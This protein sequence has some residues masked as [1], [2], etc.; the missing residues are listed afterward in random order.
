M[1][2]SPLDEH[3]KK[4]FSHY[5][6]DVPAHIWERIAAEK[7]RKKPLGFW[8]QPKKIGLLVLLALLFITGGL[9][10]YSSFDKS[11]DEKHSDTVLKVQDQKNA[12]PEVTD[13]VNPETANNNPTDDSQQ[14]NTVTTPAA[15]ATND[16]PGNKTGNATDPSTDNSISPATG[17][18]GEDKTSN[19]IAGKS[20][21]KTVIKKNNADRLF[22][23]PVAARQK[24]GITTDVPAVNGNAVSPGAVVSSKA[25]NKR[26]TKQGAAVRIENGDVAT[27]DTGETSVSLD[28][29]ENRE[30]VLNRILLNAGLLGSERNRIT[31]V[32][33][34]TVP[35]LNVPC[36]ASEKNAAG[37]KRYVE[38]YA[39]PDYS[40]KKITDTGN[41]VYLQKR[42]ESEHFSSAF[43]AGVRY[44]K[45]FN[46][47]ISFR[48]G[49]NYSQIN[50]K[51]KYAQGNIIQV[52]YIINSNGDTTG[53]YTTTGTRYK[54]TFNRY[55][56]IDIP[57][58]LGYELGNGR[59]HANF[60]AGAVINLYSWQKGDV[61]D[62][63][64]KPVTITTGKAA[65][66]YQ[67]K[68]NVG[69]GFIGAVSVYYKVTERLHIL[70]E[71]YFRY[72]FSPVSKEA[73][74]L[75][76]KYSTLGLRLGIRLDF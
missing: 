6:P 14:G 61:L 65:V 7:D 40:I 48:G 2:N 68:T 23:Q 49:L 53:S 4:Q 37:N 8:Q 45:V 36:P 16:N 54:T 50:E 34:P 55:K 46:N 9:L 60:N 5:K 64:Y 43:S 56:T 41:S 20:T 39:G 10:V 21:D 33:K 13:A 72:N 26:K 17:A 52:V 25:K 32:T 44:T 51:F 19:V 75:K 27:N 63:T 35:V 3:I 47:G 1:N 18:T 24:D 57:L 15:P 29:D 69:L 59:W 31:S 11:Q 74:T 70:A 22:K 76:Q 12:E 28:Q 42:K 71:P 73:L 58:T 62:T 38:F 30:L 67:L 66:P